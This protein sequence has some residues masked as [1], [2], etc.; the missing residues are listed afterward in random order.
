MNLRIENDFALIAARGTRRDGELLQTV[1]SPRKNSADRG[2]IFF[3]T[4]Y[5]PIHAGWFVTLQLR[6]SRLAF[7]STR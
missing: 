7:R 1:F 6:L 2:K 3:N 5:D 4:H